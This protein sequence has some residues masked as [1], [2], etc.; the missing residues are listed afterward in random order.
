M[1]KKTRSLEEKKCFY[2]HPKDR[3]RARYYFHMDTLVQSA[4]NKEV[5][6]FASDTDTADCFVETD[7]VLNGPF[8]ENSVSGIWEPL[9]E[10]P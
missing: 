10:V 5:R 2:N 6:R 4:K 9:T 3:K 1:L 8:S 7:D